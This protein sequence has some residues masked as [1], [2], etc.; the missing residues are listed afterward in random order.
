MAAQV[1]PAGRLSAPPAWALA[2][3]PGLE[4][5]AAPVALAPLAGGSVNEVFRVDTPLGCFVLRLNGPAWL[6]PGVERE[7]ELALHRA[8][9]AAGIAPAI[10]HADPAAQGLLITQFEFGRLWRQQDYADATALRRLGERLQ[11]LH[12]L[13]APQIARFDPWQVAQAYLRQMRVAPP[14]EPMARLEQC[15]A[16]LERDQRPG[17][18]VHG[19]LAE[20]NLLEGSRLWLLDWE[21]AQHGDPLMDVACVLAYYPAAQPLAAELAAAA[22]LGVVQ[23]EALALRVYIY[24]ALSWLW[25][26]ARGEPAAAP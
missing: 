24:R 19:D 15:C 17:C 5:G 10:V 12:A 18:I 13:P 2:R 22:G 1:P 3:V 16:A 6:R 26:L 8:A 7:R 11:A 4:H 21:Y 23:G 20:S 14:L 9:A 25:S